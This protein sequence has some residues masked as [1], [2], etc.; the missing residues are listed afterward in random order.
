[1]GISCFM[2]PSFLLL[3]LKI[4]KIKLLIIKMIGDQ[5][6]ICC[7]FCEIMKVF[8]IKSHLKFIIKS[9]FEIGTL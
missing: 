9:Q 5:V 6:K 8:I 1:M 7:N 2:H 3:N 4:L